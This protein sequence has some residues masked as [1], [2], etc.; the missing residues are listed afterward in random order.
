MTTP[1]IIAAATLG[2]ALLAPVA[3][4]CSST[5]DQ[6]TTTTD[7]GAVEDTPTAACATDPRAET[8]AVG[9][10]QASTKGLFTI[11]IESADPAPP[12]TNDNTWTIQLLD[13]S[14]AP[15]DG[16]TF[17]FDTY[18][19]DHR[20]HG[21]IIPA[22]APGASTGEYDITRLNLFMPGLWQITFTPT[23]SDG[24]TTDSVIWTFCVPE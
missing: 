21:S 5:S 11:V 16:A 18:M 1:R 10:K 14:G 7:S 15:V 19:P 24:T 17:T 6:S 20:H 3:S 4:G 2:L 12:Q 8:F 9:M 13:A 22:A 23:A